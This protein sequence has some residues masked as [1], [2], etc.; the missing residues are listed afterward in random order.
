MKIG[1]NDPCHCGSGQKYKKC[2]EATDEAARSAELAAA[3]AAA[4]AKAAASAE[5]ESGGTGPSAPAPSP[6]KGFGGAAAGRPPKPKG[7]Q[8]PGSSGFRKHAV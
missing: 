6:V 3:S 2:H 1:R 5:A 8:R 7:P 4:L